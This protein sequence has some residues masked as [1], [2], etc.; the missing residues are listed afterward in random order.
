[1]VEKASLSGPSAPLGPVGSAWAICRLSLFAVGSE[2]RR[3]LSFSIARLLWRAMLEPV[4][5][6]PIWWDGRKCL[7]DGKKTP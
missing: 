2:M 1:M 6:P 5:D 7:H 4:R 3:R